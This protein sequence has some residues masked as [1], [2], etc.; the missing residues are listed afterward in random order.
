MIVTF[1]PLPPPAGVVLYAH[2]GAIGGGGDAGGGGDEGG[3]EGGAHSPSHS[4]K[5]SA[6]TLLPSK[7]P[8]EVTPGDPVVT[9]LYTPSVVMGSGAFSAHMK[10]PR[11]SNGDVTYPSASMGLSGSA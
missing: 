6:Y 5:Y 9:K 1:V 3:A 4:T 2:V 7:A 8:E 10:K 11:P